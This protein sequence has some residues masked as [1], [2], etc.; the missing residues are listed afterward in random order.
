[1]I[2]GATFPSSPCILDQ[3]FWMERLIT[4]LKTSETKSSIH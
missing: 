2:T 4:Q 1:M 3:A